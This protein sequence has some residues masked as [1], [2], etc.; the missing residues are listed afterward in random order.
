MAIK[1][2]FQAD[3]YNQ[4]KYYIGDST[5]VK[6][7]L[8]VNGGDRFIETNTKDQYIF[9]GTAWHKEIEGGS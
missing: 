7:T 9:D 4:P 2:P 1:G 5:D 3:R 6:P 8:N